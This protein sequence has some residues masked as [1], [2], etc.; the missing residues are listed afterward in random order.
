MYILHF[1]IRLSKLCFE[2]YHEM[3]DKHPT[4]ISFALEL[5][6]TH[7]R[8]KSQAVFIIFITK[9]GVTLVCSI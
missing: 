9:S 4:E 1:Y 3:M 2:K 6:G 8:P 7:R 5:H